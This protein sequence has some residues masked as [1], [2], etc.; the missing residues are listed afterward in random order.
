MSKKTEKALQRIKKCKDQI[1]ISKEI[2]EE[3][4]NRKKNLIVAWMNYQRAVCGVP[5]SW[6]IKYLELIRISNKIISLT[7]EL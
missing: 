2:L 7:V 5:H 1:L 6:I 3:C 4:T